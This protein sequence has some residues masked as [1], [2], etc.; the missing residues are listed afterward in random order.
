MSWL[1][2]T[3]V[4]VGIVAGVGAG[5]RWPPERSAVAL[6][7]L[8]LVPLSVGIWQV[9]DVLPRSLLKNAGAVVLMGAGAGA[10]IQGFRGALSRPGALDAYLRI[11]VHG[12]EALAAT[13][14]LGRLDGIGSLA[15]LPAGAGFLSGLLLGRSMEHRVR[16]RWSIVGGMCV[17][18][19]AA[20]TTS[21]RWALL[22][23]SVIV[24]IG[25]EVF[26]RGF[27]FG[28]LR[29]RWGVL[30][31]GLSSAV[32]FAAVHVQLVHALPILVLALLFSFLYERTKS[33]L[34]AIVAHGMNNLVAV[35]ALSRG[36]GS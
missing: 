28:G 27:V 1:L 9:L 36:W 30:A 2:A 8:S 7:V 32:F 12:G 29:V 4:V 25:E 3:L 21:L 26:F 24:P 18:G 15:L 23:P 33:L 17:L 14:A 20:V 22:L 34:P 19:A 16:R 31:G 11:L 10:L 6:A 13:L 5:S 35:L